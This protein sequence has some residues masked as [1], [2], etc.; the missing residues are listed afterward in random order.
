MQRVTALTSEQHYA[1]RV[2]VLRE[3]TSLLSVALAA[4]E[5]HH[6]L[7]ASA[8]SGAF[9]FVLVEVVLH[10]FVVGVG[11]EHAADRTFVK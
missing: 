4:R 10:F 8:A 2:R 7:A 9:N 3:S 1:L 5:G 6:V 11:A